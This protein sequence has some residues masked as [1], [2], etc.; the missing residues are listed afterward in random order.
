M[1]PDPTIPATKIQPLQTT[2][3]IPSPTKDPE[4]DQ[5]RETAPI[6]VNS[7]RWGAENPLIEGVRGQEEDDLEGPREPEDV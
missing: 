2:P 3:S 1:P 4:S 6:E 5:P 7:F